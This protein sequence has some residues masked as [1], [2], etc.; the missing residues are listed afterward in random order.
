MHLPLILKQQRS[1]TWSLAL[2]EDGKLR[3]EFTQFSS[4]PPFIYNFL[5]R[6]SVTHSFWSHTW[7]GGTGKAL[8]YQVLGYQE[9][10]PLRWLFQS[11][12]VF[13]NLGLWYEGQ[14]TRGQSTP[15]S[16]K[17]E[18]S[19][20]GTGSEHQG[21][22]PNCRQPSNTNQGPRSIAVMIDRQPILSLRQLRLLASWLK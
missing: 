10:S 20:R 2:L 9:L 13:S 6:I 14:A 7:T 12:L 3:H 16:C 22:A 5:G 18:M 1:L 11:D 17:Q 19:S 4:S 21:Q 8:S 15:L